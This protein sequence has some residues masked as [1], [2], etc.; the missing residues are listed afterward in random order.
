MEGVEDWL[1][2]KNWVP[3]PLHEGRCAAQFESLNQQFV[4]STAKKRSAAALRERIFSVCV[5]S[6]LQ[7]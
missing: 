7:H 1:L 3:A 5:G 4:M 2:I 6:L